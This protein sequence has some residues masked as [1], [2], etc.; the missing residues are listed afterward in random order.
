MKK[1]FSAV[2]WQLISVYSLF[3][4]LIS[5]GFMYKYDFYFNL[6]AVVIS[7]FGISLIKTENLKNSFSKNI[8]ILILIFSVLFILLL[9]IIPYIDNTIPLG[10]D[11]GLYKYG[12]E[13]GLINLDKWVVGGMEPGFLYLM[14]I[15][16][17]AF[18]TNFLLIYGFIL[19]NLLLGF[20]IYLFSKEYF[21]KDVALFSILIFSISFVQFKVFTYL[22]YKNVIG[23]SLIFFS[24]YF[25]K[26]NK[27]EW[28]VFFGILVG[29]I[30]RPSFYIFG[31]SYF[32]YSF[33]SPF[34][35]KKYNLKKLLFN[36][37]YGVIILTISLIFYIGNFWPSIINVLPW[38]VNS[39]TE[40]GTSPGT[41]ISFF[42]YQFSVLFYLPL[43]LLGFFYILKNKKLDIFFFYTVLTAVI[44]YFQ[45]FFFNRF[46]IFLDI[47]MII[48]AAIGSSILIEK[49]PLGFLV[50]S[51]L[52]VSSGIASFQ[53][54]INANPLIT[55]N[56]LDLIN[57]LSKNIEKDAF[58]MTIS[59]QYSPWVLAYGERRAITPGLFDEDKW[60][61]SQ[62]N[63]FISTQDKEKT[64]ELMSVYSGKIYLFA[65]DK[66]FKNP[67]FEEYLVRGKDKSFKYIC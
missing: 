67:C 28:F 16:N 22:Y 1:T 14:S 64:K 47:A 24:F 53:A 2:F 65:G 38:V 29:I 15:L 31:L 33:T 23:L 17:K 36:V 66:G 43:S 30:H 63:I 44:V 4:V 60:N 55:E 51:I 5:I 13:K 27:F 50:L 58:L 45:F 10:Y 7:I 41:F 12:I 25:L 35:N 59:S 52:F 57:D 20:S 18:S 42:E 19:F 62:W 49:K 8:H 61:Q 54:S 37:L 39:F 56:Q 21:G 34:E 40:P 3:I 46:I 26:K 9:R 48:L 6:F 32:I 11:T